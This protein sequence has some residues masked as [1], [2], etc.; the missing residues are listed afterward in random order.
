[1]A[2]VYTLRKASRL[3][4]N[5]FMALWLLKNDTLVEQAITEAEYRALAQKGAGAPANKTGDAAATWLVAYEA[6]VF[7]TPDGTLSPGDVTD[8]WP[9]LVRVFLG[10]TKVSVPTAKAIG[11]LETLTILPADLPPGVT[12]E[13]GVAT[14]R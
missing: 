3:P 2:T 1:M 13:A 12:I 9:G 10:D 5:A 14:V 4:G 7:D 8:A 6:W 11:P